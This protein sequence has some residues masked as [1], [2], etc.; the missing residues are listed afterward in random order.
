MKKSHIIISCAL[1]MHLCHAS[2]EHPME[3]DETEAAPTG[4][5]STVKE[6]AADILQALGAAAA[7]SSSAAA[8]SSSSAAQAQSP[9]AQES[10]AAIRT[11]IKQLLDM[12]D[13]FKNG[14]FGFAKDPQLAQSLL[15]QVI[16]HPQATGPQ[17]TKAKAALRELEQIQPAAAMPVAQQ[18]AAA[19]P[20]RPIPQHRSLVIPRQ[21]Q[22]S[23]CNTPVHHTA[24]AHSMPSPRQNA[25]QSPMHQPAAAGS[26]S[27]S[28]QA[29]PA[30]S[31][32]QRLLDDGEAF[33]ARGDYARAEELYRQVAR[34]TAPTYMQRRAA[35]II[36]GLYL[37]GSGGIMRNFGTAVGWFERAM[38]PGAF[39][40]TLR[41]SQLGLGEI[42][43]TGGYGV[44][45]NPERAEYF[46]RQAMLPGVVAD[47]IN[48]ARKRL[49]AMGLTNI[50][51]SGAASATAVASQQINPDEFQ[52]YIPGSVPQPAVAAS[53]SSV[54]QTS[55][56]RSYLLQELNAAASLAKDGQT[57]AAVNRY[58]GIVD[59]PFTPIDLRRAAQYHLGEL[60]RTGGVNGGHIKDE[61]Q[62]KALFE[63]AMLPGASKEIQRLA[64]EKLNAMQ[65]GNMPALEQPASSAAAASSNA[66]SLAQPASNQLPAVQPAGALR[67]RRGVKR[68]RATIGDSADEEDD[69]D[70]PNKDAKKE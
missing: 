50:P 69:Q 34:S 4:Q 36:G 28:G 10:I 49:E 35:Q 20:T 37:R 46:F 24:A 63:Q 29:G 48:V 16:K 19:G 18:A 58:A 23:A 3:V 31:V 6:E 26:S 64:Q 44:E 54:Q 9:V 25:L 5:Q 45:P 13:R 65:Y 57:F 67:T 8:A 61:A 59:Y 39:T 14:T 66:Q 56:A 41:R 42:Y 30:V 7:S 33:M 38:G 53:S 32:W 17:M 11:K 70:Q 15:K 55:S 40:D 2:Q 12:A 60:N 1:I 62:A 27:G 21:T 43:K 52:E 51:A 22:A 47:V 68:E